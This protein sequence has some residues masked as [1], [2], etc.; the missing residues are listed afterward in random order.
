M[1]CTLG[2]FWPFILN[3]SVCT[4][5]SQ[6]PTGPQLSSSSEASMSSFSKSVSLCFINSL[7]PF[8]SIPHVRG[9][10]DIFLLVW[11]TSLSRT[12]TV[13]GLTLVAICKWHNFILFKAEY[14]TVC[15]HPIFFIH[16]S[17]DGRLVCSHVLVTVN[18][19]HQG[20]YILSDHSGSS[21]MGSSS[22]LLLQ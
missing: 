9:S 15:M 4:C 6:L 2:P 3:V 1:C 20:A 7:V 10:C 17:A 13:P 12:V 21:G 11:L 14:S 22:P 8:F 18:S 16:L 5:P 19:E